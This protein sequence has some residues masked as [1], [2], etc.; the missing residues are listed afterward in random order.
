M[1]Y[2]LNKLANSIKSYGLK[3][4]RGWSLAHYQYRTHFPFLLL[5]LGGGG[6]ALGSGLIIP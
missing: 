5:K 4:G 6:W 2:R 1:I 3:T